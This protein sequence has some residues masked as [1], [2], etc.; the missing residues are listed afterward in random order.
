MTAV[1]QVK[2][3]W[4]T[5]LLPDNYSTLGGKTV[6]YTWWEWSSSCQWRQHP[7]HI[8]HTGQPCTCRRVSM[9]AEF[10]TY[11][12][13][14]A[15]LA[16]YR[17]ARKKKWDTIKWSVTQGTP[18]TIQQQWKSIWAFSKYLKQTGWNFLSTAVRILSSI[19]RPQWLHLSLLCCNVVNV[20]YQQYYT[21]NKTILATE[22]YTEKHWPLS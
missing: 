17:A 20:I 15:G 2:R 13:W 16:V 11:L 21:R 6:H 5:T 10:G 1:W 7:H 4:N 3:S 14:V 8:L 12:L 19:G 18:S 22:S 9:G